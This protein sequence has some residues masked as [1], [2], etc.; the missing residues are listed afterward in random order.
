MSAERQL[1]IDEVFLEV[2]DLAGEERR[3]RIASRCAG[4]DDLRREVESLLGH[5]DGAGDFL[6]PSELRD[7]GLL[8]DG[9]S[10]PPQS[11]IDD[12]T[13]LG[14]LGSGGMG[15]V[16]LAEQER[17]RRT[18]AL[19]LI[20][21]LASTP[22]L[23]RRFEHEAEILAKLQHPGIAQV[24]AAGAADTG[25]GPQPYIAMELV[26]GVTL[27]QFAGASQLVLA[28]RLR[29]V[30]KICDA[31]QHAHQRGIIHRDLKPGN[32]LVDE[33][34]GSA[35]PKILDF[36]VARAVDAD[37]DVTS[38]H[39]SAGQ[40]VGTLAY[41]SPEQ[42]A[43][44]PGDIDTR[45]DVY[46]LGVLLFELLTDELPIKTRGRSLPEAARMI[47]DD[48]PARLS[49]VKR[50]YRGDLD[51]IVAKALEKDRERRYQSAAELAADIQRHLDGRPIAAKQDSAIYVLRMQ[52][53]RYKHFVAAGVF[54]LLA[55]IT[56]AV[57]AF[58][59]AANESRANAQAQ[60]AL[61]DATAQRLRADESADKL[62]AQLSA[63]NVEQGRL[64]GLAK[65]I[66]VANELIWR[67]HLLNPKSDHTFWALWELYSRAPR[68]ATVQAYDVEATCITACAAKP[69]V[70]SGDTKGRIKLWDAMTLEPRGEL[71][72][73]TKA[74]LWGLAFNRE[75]T[76]LIS[77]DAAGSMV[78]WDLATGE[79]SR[80]VATG[81]TTLRGLS[82]SA[83][84]KRVL[85]GGT[86][87]FVR[88]WELA[89]GEKLRDAKARRPVMMATYDRLGT[90]F[91]AGEDD[92]SVELWKPGAAD[93][94]LLTGHNEAVSALSFAPDGR[95]ATGSSDRTVRIWDTERGVEISRLTAPNGYLRSITFNDDGTQLYSAGWWTIDTWDVA[96]GQRIRV[97][98][99]QIRPGMIT[100]SP[101]NSRLF[102]AQA[103][104]TVDV[105]ETSRQPAALTLPG[106]TGRVTAALTRDGRIAATGDYAGTARLWDTSNG[107]LLAEIKAH[108]GKLRNILMH[109]EGR[110]LATASERVRLWDLSTG[111]MMAETSRF[112]GGL[113][114]C[115][116]M[117]YDQRRSLLIW[118]GLDRSIYF[119]RVPTLQ[120][121]VKLPTAKAQ[122]LSLRLSPDGSTL[123]SVNR[124]DEVKIWDIETALAGG[125]TAQSPP[126]LLPVRSGPQLQPWTAAFSPDGQQLVLGDWNK[127]LQIW[128]FPA[129]RYVNS[130]EGHTALVYDMSYKPGDPSKIAT[131]SADGTIKLWSLPEHRCLLTMDPFGGWDAITVEFTSDGGRLLCGAADGAAALWDLHHFD[132]HIAGNLEY[133]I[134]KFGGSDI[135]PSDLQTLRTWAKGVLTR[136]PVSP[137]PEV[138]AD[139]D[140]SLGPAAIEVWGRKTIEAK[141]ATGS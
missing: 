26:N 44:D 130:L 49:S 105:W 54:A 65:Q 78:V 121:V 70:A 103:D 129:R 13:I 37:F 119:S 73:P 124:Q 92:G 102:C 131:C 67:E 100:L 60:D 87:G 69:L 128:D 1:L 77:G 99:V 19:K 51:V 48:Q 133:A 17:P 88:E 120:T 68:L 117:V 82:L 61:L 139:I 41:M 21:R 134:G 10:L 91:A 18:V 16:Y 85:T 32:I 29:L 11:K 123:I 95:L 72:T 9:A 90:S 47:R 109:P 89:T 56:V 122:L 39:T 76:I 80:V 4:D 101:D 23:L 86:D 94:V 36:G 31:V 104:G 74:T 136:R 53:R 71:V 75:G 12:Y 127:V 27:S 5:H 135:K 62:R 66:G 3:A 93:P 111:A 58:I 42:V 141:P 138:T 25:F 116:A 118:C 106:H 2:A 14:V 50:E 84:N 115:R 113:I 132:R 64:H 43:A 126:P 33:S 137:A 45:S 22:G 112:D 97:W 8:D 15:V 59:Q 83:D 114:S 40:L 98:P 6:S 46:A 107:H 81:H 34:S 24:F 35:Q 110:W 52:M 63:S 38:L 30:M 28:D 125:Y 79:P 20:R 140:P 7:A 96:S 57:F 55:I 108:V